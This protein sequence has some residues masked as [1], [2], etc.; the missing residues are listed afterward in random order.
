MA[1]Q[2]FANK[3][4]NE[5]T[6]A[7]KEFDAKL[8][9]VQAAAE[10]A[11]QT[12]ALGR[13]AMEAELSKRLEEEQKKVQE[14]YSQKLAAARAEAEREYS[15]TRAVQKRATRALPGFKSERRQIV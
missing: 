2:A 9:E 6:N 13:A 8:A 12:V 14:E 3:M 15:Q 1:Q 10:T 7:Q 11:E 5:R 4:T